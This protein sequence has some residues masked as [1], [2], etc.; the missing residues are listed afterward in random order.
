MRRATELGRGRASPSSD[1]VKSLHFAPEPAAIN[2]KRK[3][4]EE[5][6]SRTHKVGG[7]RSHAV[8]PQAPDPDPKREQRG[9]GD[10]KDMKTLKRH[11][12]NHWIVPGEIGEPE[13]TKHK[14]GRE[15]EDAVDEL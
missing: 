3:R 6:T 8:D 11:L 12:V 14:D 15:N 7:R 4:D 1:Q 9:N 2:H 10:E 5:R 13:K